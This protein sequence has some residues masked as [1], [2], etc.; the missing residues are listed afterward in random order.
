MNL[1]NL[2]YEIEKVKPE[3][4]KLHAIVDMFRDIII[5][6]NGGSNSI[7]SHIAQDYTKC[8]GKRA[9]SFSDPSRLTCY[10]NDYG[11]DNAYMEFL[12]DFGSTK[13]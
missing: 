11:R 8:L 4:I 5:I 10:I 9:I 2:I 13:T 12:K 7:A 6:G 3:I 1:D